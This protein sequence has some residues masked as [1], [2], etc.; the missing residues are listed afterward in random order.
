MG[1]G[2]R[3]HLDYK[4]PISSSDTL[5]LIDDTL[6]AIYNDSTEVSHDLEKPPLVHIITTY[7][8]Y[9]VLIVV[10]HIRDGFKRVLMPGEFR[11]YTSQD[12]YA[13]IQNGFGSFYL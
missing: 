9:L 12:G 10:G 2:K 8:S 7:L 5:K 3:A 11:Q 6:P 1:K 13:A 4:P